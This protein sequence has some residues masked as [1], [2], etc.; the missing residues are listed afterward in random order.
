MW[1]G[2]DP[3]AARASWENDEAVKALVVRVAPGAS[4]RS[5]EGGDPPLRP[6]HQ[7]RSAEAADRG[8]RGLFE[9]I[10]QERSSIIH[11]IKRYRVRQARWPR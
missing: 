6:R 11:G 3:T 1:N 10:N 4:P 8:L 7:R 5:G 9:T 2:P